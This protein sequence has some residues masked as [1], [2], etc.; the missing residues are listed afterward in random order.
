MIANNDLLILQREKNRI[1][2]SIITNLKDLNNEAIEFVC[3]N[4]WIKINCKNNAFSF[5][6]EF[7]EICKKALGSVDRIYAQYGDDLLILVDCI[8]YF[9]IKVGPFNEVVITKKQLI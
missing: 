1:I 4:G 8:I 5:G 2:K 6:G 3:N 7:G 9:S